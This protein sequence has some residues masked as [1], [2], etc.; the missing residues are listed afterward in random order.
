MGSVLAVGRVDQFLYPFYIK[1]ITEGKITNAEVTE[2]AEEF[3]VKLSYN[4]VMLPNYG[5][6]TA[7]EL[8]A[9]N[10]AVT[11]GGVDKDGRDATNELSYLFM[12]AIEDIRSMTNSFSIRISPAVTHASTSNPFAFTT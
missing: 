4:L 9:D 5:K 3:L 8:G 7:S 1:D 11:V 2:L 10:A 6:A 12:D